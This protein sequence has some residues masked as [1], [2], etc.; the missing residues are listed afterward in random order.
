MALPTLSVIVPNYNH[1]RFIPEAL[2]CILNQ[3]VRP[4]EVL[5]IDDGSTDNSR[6]VVEEI[7]RRE[8]ILKLFPNPRNR[9]VTYSINRGISQARGDYVYGAAADDQVLPGFFAEALAMAAEYPQAGI[10]F[11]DMIEV[12]DHGKRLAYFGLRGRKEK[13]Y[14]TPRAFLD[15]YLSVEPPGHSLCAATVYRRDRL[16]E[17]G[18]YRDGLGS[19]VD[20]FV[21]RAIG[22]KHGACYIPQPFVQ[23]RYAPSS[24]AHATTT[25]EALR[26]VRRAARQ[27]RSARFRDCF[28]ESYV[29][30]WEHE[31]RSYLLRQHL[32]QLPARRDAL[33]REAGTRATRAAAVLDRMKNRPLLGMPLRRF[34]SLQ[35]AATAALSSWFVSSVQRRIE[36]EENYLYWRL[37]PALRRAG[38]VKRLCEFVSLPTRETP[39]LAT[40]AMEPDGGYGYRVDL[41]RFGMFAPSDQ[42]SV[43]LLRLFE[44]G[45]PLSGPHHAHDAIRGLGQGRFSHWGNYLHFSTSDNSDPRRNGRHYTIVAPRTLL[46]CARS[47]VR[48]RGTRK[49]G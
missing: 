28:P 25:W 17:M 49:A 18:G 29:R 22:L 39:P 7:A 38:L 35:E 44:D 26:I 8:P 46:T 16:L 27:M 12:D 36:R 15:D 32:A 45:K 11:G 40:E 4:M 13:T 30:T 47:F 23:W 33:L 24:L 34:P 37:D 19:W 1:A 5:V 42:E 2:R 6:Q 20:T 3:S 9:G 41:A 21:S 48:S 10:I 43:S 31:F 14:F